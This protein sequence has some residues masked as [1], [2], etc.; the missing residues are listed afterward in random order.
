M[1]QIQKNK[2]FSFDDYFNNHPGLIQLYNVSSE[3]I[4]KNLKYNSSNEIYNHNELFSYKFKLKDIKMVAKKYHLRLNGNKDNLIK[5]CYFY[6]YLSDKII[7]I[8]KRIRGYLQRKIN[9]LRGPAFIKRNICN[10]Q[11][12]FLSFEKIQT[13]SPNQ[14]FSYSDGDFIYGFNVISFHNLILKNKENLLNPYNRKEIPETILSSFQH[15]LKLNNKLKLKIET[16]VEKQEG[17]SL[18]KLNELKIVELFQKMDSLGHCT[19]PN[20]LINLTNHDL[21]TFYLKLMDIWDYRIQIDLE[22]KRKIC[23]PLGNPFRHNYISLG[24]SKNSNLINI[25]KIMNNFIH[26][27]ADRDSQSLGCYYVLGALTLISKN[28][29]NS[30]PWLF[31]AFHY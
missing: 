6:L 2:P 12:D 3:N 15:L 22:T 18:E 1:T 27:T 25:L 10:N 19:N 28:A 21:Y 13:I 30:L 20:W 26:P 9:S 4:K 14:F 11:E 24:M 16:D 8:Q 5:R 29:E 31:E 17:L 7:L 23:P